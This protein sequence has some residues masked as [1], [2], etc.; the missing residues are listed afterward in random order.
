MK[1]T[2][3]V[4]TALR[5][6]LLRPPRLRSHAYCGPEQTTSSRSRLSSI[7][8][9]CRVTVLAPFGVALLSLA[10]AQNSTETGTGTNETAPADDCVDRGD[11]CDVFSRM[12]QCT[13]PRFESLLRYE[14]RAAAWPL[15]AG[16]CRRAH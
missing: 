9:K 12:G 3:S 8:G 4:A 7:R 15:L 6:I 13:S 2:S 1:P 14:S 11:G 16:A 10:Y 5:A